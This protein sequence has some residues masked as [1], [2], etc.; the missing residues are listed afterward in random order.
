MTGLTLADLARGTLCPD[1]P[2]TRVDVRAAIDLVAEKAHQAGVAEERWRLAMLGE[3]HCLAADIPEPE[4]VGILACGGL[5]VS[6]V[7]GVQLIHR[8]PRPTP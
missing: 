2:A 6:N 7:D 4:F 5:C 3:V 8:M 1:E